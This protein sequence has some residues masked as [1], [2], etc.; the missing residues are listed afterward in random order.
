MPTPTPSERQRAL[1]ALAALS[2]RELAAIW[3]KLNLS[4]PDRLREPLAE[5]LAQIA[6]KYGAPAATLAADWYDEARADAGAP[7]S[8]RASPADL[9]EAARFESLAGWS[10]D[11]LFGA[12]PDSP[13]ALS[14]VSGGLSRIVFDQ[15]RDTTV[16]A[17][18]LDPAGPTY[19]RHASANACAFCKMLA[20]RGAT[21][22]SAESA[23]TVVGRGT[24]VSTNIGRTRGRKALG[25]R[26]RGTQSL[27]AKYHDHCKCTAIEVFPGE[28]YEEAPY[29]HEWRETYNESRVFG[30]KYGAIDVKATLAEMRKALGT[31]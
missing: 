13:L 25:I 16:A 27:G 29:V 30:G 3:R 4:R 19:A 14:R 1:T 12:T 2:T 26:E 28:T 17:V 8:F 6:D 5:L 24:D 18:E 22:T 21:Y 11:A 15:A 20:T 9:P 7:G 31:N 10:V 23:A